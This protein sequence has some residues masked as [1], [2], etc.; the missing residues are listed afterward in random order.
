MGCVSRQRNFLGQCPVKSTVWGW[1]FYTAQEVCLRSSPQVTGCESKVLAKWDTD[2]KVKRMRQLQVIQDLHI[3][4]ARKTNLQI[5]STEESSSYPQKAL[6]LAQETCQGRRT[7][8]IS[9]SVATT[10]S[11]LET[12]WQLEDRLSQIYM[13]SQEVFTPSVIRICIC[14][15]IINVTLK[16]RK[17]DCILTL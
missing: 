1:G 9:Q 16:F 15:C 6:R 13:L 10:H 17:E 14:M 11:T 5:H 12:Q 4:V 8:K 2:E 3:Q 7:Y